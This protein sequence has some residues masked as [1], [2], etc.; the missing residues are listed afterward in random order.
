MQSLCGRRPTDALGLTKS[1]DMAVVERCHH[2]FNYRITSRAQR[3]SAT[4]CFPSSAAAWHIPNR[5]VPR[6]RV[7]LRQPAACMAPLKPVVLLTSLHCV[8][9]FSTYTDVT[10]PRRPDTSHQRQRNGGGD[11][12]VIFI[13]KCCSDRWWSSVMPFPVSLRVHRMGSGWLYLCKP[14]VINNYYPLQQTRLARVSVILA[15]RLVEID[16]ICCWKCLVNRNI[17]GVVRFVINE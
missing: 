1:S 8:R 2:R 9:W 10:R 12:C 16:S 14:Y 5:H 3:H 17:G 11:F 4:A 15:Q 6:A 7:Q 13:S